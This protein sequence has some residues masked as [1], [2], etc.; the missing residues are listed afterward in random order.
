MRLYSSLLPLSLF[1]LNSFPPSH[2]RFKPGLPIHLHFLFLSILIQFSLHPHPLYISRGLAEYSYI[3][4]ISPFQ[5]LTILIKKKW[6]GGI[7]PRKKKCISI[8]NPSHRNINPFIHPFP[9]CWGREGDSEKIKFLFLFLFWQRILF[10]IPTLSSKH[11][12]RAESLSH[13]L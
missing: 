7:Y 12:S 5:W 4:T 3:Y 10:F 2:Y 8:Y 6:G 1:L 9:W 11:S 13:L